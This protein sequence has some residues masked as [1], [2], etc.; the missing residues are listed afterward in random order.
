MKQCECV[1]P[2]CGPGTLPFA[3]REFAFK[4]QDGTFLRYYSFEKMAELKAAVKKHVPVA[5]SVGAVYS[6]QV[7]FD[8]VSKKHKLGSTLEATHVEC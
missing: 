4:L 8:G 7:R 6:E 2:H 1:H 3:Q 5:I